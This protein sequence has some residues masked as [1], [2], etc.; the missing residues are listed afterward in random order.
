MGKVLIFVDS[1]EANSGIIEYFWQYDCDVQKKM[2]L[3]GDFV[4]SDRVII[5]KKSVLSDTPVVINI[6][7]KIRIIS[8]EKASYLFK[9]CGISMKV[10]GI[11]FD[12][13][14][15]DWFDVYDVTAHQSDDVYGISFSPL[16]E[17][18][19]KDERS[20]HL[21]MTGGHNVFVFRNKRIKCIPTS[22]LR[23]GDVLIL[24]PPKLPQYEP[25]IYPSFDGYLE[26][27]QLNSTKGFDVNENEFKLHSAPHRYKIPALNEDFF[28][29]LGLWVAEGYF[30]SEVI[31]SQKDKERNALIEKYLGNVFGHFSKRNDCYMCGGKVYARL[32]SDIF[33]SKKGAENKFLPSLLFTS[34]NNLKAAFIRGYFFGDGYKN[35]FKRYNPQLKATSKSKELI[36]GLSYMLYSMGIENTVR[37]TY[38]KYKNERRKYYE[39]SIKTKSLSKFIEIIGQIPS[40]EIRIDKCRGT[41][42]PSYVR[43]LFYRPL[44]K[45]KEE[46][47]EEF[48]DIVKKLKCLYDESS[49]YIEKFKNIVS[50]YTVKKEFSK[51]YNIHYSTTRNLT[52]GYAKHSVLFLDIINIIRKEEGLKE[53]NIDFVKLRSILRKLNVSTYF[54]Y[55]NYRLTSEFFIR[56]LYERISEKVGIESIFLLLKMQ[57]G[58][59]FLEKIKNIEKIDGRHKV[60]DFSVNKSENFVGGLI[61]TLLHNTTKDF[62]Q[63]I[64]DKRLFQQLK[65]MKDNFEK[66]VLIIEGEESLYGVLQPNIIRGTLAAIA[67]DMS[68]PIIWT[69]DMA[70]TAGIVYWIARREQLQENRANVLRNKKTPETIEE[71]QEYLV[72]SLPDVSIVRAKALL[73]YF[74]SPNNVFNAKEEELTDVKGIGK[75]ISERI[76]R[77][78]DSE[79]K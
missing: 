12:N 5:E 26:K 32:F 68:I 66:P 29:I 49:A 15:I 64:T 40:K 19:Y 25:K 11:D 44:L 76:K 61:P 74:K 31:I 18:K 27:V 34:P 55:K 9:R 56:N 52:N 22:E 24:V 23:K 71:K 20:F 75:K 69:K 13:N 2:L 53:I 65:A 14:K 28:F 17:S 58:E 36:V 67:V 72:S 62:I 46:E 1:R 7:G 59:V 37:L 70:D 73:K 77:V 63:S 8:I 57:K 54:N 35:D 30:D 16:R 50:K 41:K 10:M 60:Y 43:L 45:L 33:D 79:Y 48:F 39:I 38:S 51:K 3:F 42:L 6:D 4:A 47:L 21:K 78:L